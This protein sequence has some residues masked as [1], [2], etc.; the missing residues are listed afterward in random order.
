VVALDRQVHARLRL[1]PAT[2]L[3]FAAGMSAVPLLS[4]EFGDAA[5][6]YAIVFV[7]G[8][9]QSVV[10]AVLTGKPNGPNVYLDAAGRW[11]AQYVPAYVRR[12]P[13]LTA[14]TAPD[15]F[16]VCI[17]A[18]CSG[19]DATEG[20]Q[21]FAAEGEPSPLLQQV[22]HNLADYQRHAQLTEAF[23][24]RLVAAGVLVD[25]DAKADLANG[26][27]MAL[28]GFCVVDE[29]HL[30]ALPDSTSK[31]WL[32]SGDLGL[33]YAHLLSLGNLLQLL[34]RQPLDETLSSDVPKS[35]Q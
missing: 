9:D 24:Q 32:A 28:R 2:D 15:Q 5:R 19:F 12:Y 17:D 3:A 13:F 23:T 33:I 29:A 35:I 10:P 7:R 8:T 11:N 16:T 34:R 30:R 21:L 14:Q 4:A 26:Q 22:V 25:A 31:E 20:A 18:A 1:K 6:E 27:A